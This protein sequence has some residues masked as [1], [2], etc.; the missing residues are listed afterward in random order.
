M[1]EHKPLLTL[2]AGISFEL[3]DLVL[4][5]GWAEFHDLRMVVELDYSTEGE[6]YEEVLT[7]YP[8][9]SAFRRWMIWRA[10]HDIV[11]QPMMGRAMRFP[12]VADALEHLIPAQ[13]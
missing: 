2:P 12:C 9:N 8:R 7:F 3:S 10:S 4:V 5:Q 11:V 6:E 1:S 13:P